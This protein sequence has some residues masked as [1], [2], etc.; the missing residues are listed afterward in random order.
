[1]AAASFEV[2]LMDVNMP[3]LGGLEATRRLRAAQGPNAEVAVIALTAASGPDEIAACRR[4]GMSA[5]VSKPVAS[6][7]LFQ[8]IEQV[9][10][11][12]E[13]FEPLAAS[14]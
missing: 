3:G 12:G 10:D 5:F 7:E 14:A 11:G 1:L 8:A 13:A 4:A 6:A 2:V 9:L